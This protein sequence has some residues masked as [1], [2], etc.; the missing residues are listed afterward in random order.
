LHYNTVDAAR[1]STR[2]QDYGDPNK[3]KVTILTGGVIASRATIELMAGAPVTD[4]MVE[5]KDSS[6]TQPRSGSTA[7]T[8][9]SSTPLYQRE[10]PSIQSS[11]RDIDSPVG[12]PSAMKT[13]ALLHPGERRRNRPA[14]RTRIAVVWRRPAAARRHARAPGQ[15]R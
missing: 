13:V 10:P 15:R 2:E 1:P 3:T 11:C 5:A 4:Y 8:A 7:A 9:R 12:E 6:V 14:R